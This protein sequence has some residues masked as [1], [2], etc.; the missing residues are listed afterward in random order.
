MPS[1]S[2]LDVYQCNKIWNEEFWRQN[3]HYCFCVIM[4]CFSW[5]NFL[6]VGIVYISFQST[7]TATATRHLNFYLTHLAVSYKHFLWWHQ[8]YWISSWSNPAVNF[9]SL[10]KTYWVL[11][12]S[13]FVSWYMY[14]SLH[15]DSSRECVEDQHWHFC[16]WCCGVWYIWQ[17]T[18]VGPGRP[19][20]THSGWQLA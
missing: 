4:F 18:L 2:S 19:C 1:S 12:K 9:S 5:L 16:W 20:Q 6:T 17:W 15:V 13:S 8:R 11:H 10:Q 3:C 7:R 14:M